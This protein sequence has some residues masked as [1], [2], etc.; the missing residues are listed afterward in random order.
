M[1]TRIS[2]ATWDLYKSIIND[3]HDTFNQDTVIWRRLVTNLDRYGE[4]S[5][6]TYQDIE[7]KVL[8]SYNFFRTW[9]IN[10]ETPSGGIDKQSTV[11]ILNMQYLRD[12]GWVTTE[13]YFDFKPDHDFF[14]H[15]GIM[16]RGD[17][18]TDMAQANEE[19]ILCQVILKRID[20]NTGD[21]YFR[22]AEP[23]PG[24]G[25]MEIGTTFI[26]Y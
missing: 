13:D 2:T 19:T 4:S 24:I 12:N 5:S 26:V 8:M 15:K 9:P 16:Y 11:M 23:L 20:P 21:D 18:D 3:A 10:A 14:I 6:N 17:G 22:P 25:L 1:A 7:L